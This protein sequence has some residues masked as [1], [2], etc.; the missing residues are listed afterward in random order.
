MQCGMI[1]GNKG[2]TSK[3]TGGAGLFAC[4]GVWSL[5]WLVGR[6]GGCVLG[7]FACGFCR[8]R[9]N[10]KIH[11]ENGGEPLTR[12]KKFG[13]MTCFILGAWAIYPHFHLSAVY[14][15]RRENTRGCGENQPTAPG[16]SRRA[17]RAAAVSQ[18]TGRT[19]G[20][21]RRGGRREGSDHRKRGKTPEQRP[22]TAI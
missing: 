6:Q 15:L 17:V 1:S 8:G 19:D 4:L 3:K 11:R 7:C 22:S 21:G 13:I 9:G 12:W 18:G 5:G 20:R 16:V 10:E 14:H 2:K